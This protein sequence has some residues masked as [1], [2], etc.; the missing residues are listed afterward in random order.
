MTQDIKFS[1]ADY[2]EESM[3]YYTTAMMERNFHH[4]SFKGFIAAEY[5]NIKDG[6]YR[7]IMD[8]KG[9]KPFAI[10][11][12]DSPDVTM[13]NNVIS[14]IPIKG[15]YIGVTIIKQDDVYTIGVNTFN[16]EATKISVRVVDIKTTTEEMLP[17]LELDFLEDII[18]GNYMTAFRA[19]VDGINKLGNEPTPNHLY[20]IDKYAYN[21]MRRI[22]TRLFVNMNGSL[23]TAESTEG[24]FEISNNT[25]DK[26]NG[27]EV[28]DTGI[29]RVYYYPRHSS[30]YK[31]VRGVRLKYLT[32]EDLDK[33][34]NIFESMYDNL[35]VF[36]LKNG[37]EVLGA[38]MGNKYI[39]LYE[40][41]GTPHSLTLTP[42]E[43]R[44][45]VSY[46]TV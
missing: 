3:Q 7:F 6:I 11:T 29:Y 5:L 14:V 20:T 32:R 43:Y 8:E 38:V 44:L 9:K 26:W 12:L 10:R 34:L 46:E 4:G 2:L 30:H 31:F 40:M 42:N 1:E 21:P 45:I 24:I 41:N 37:D 36:T 27:D 39:I 23:C 25:P 19:I 35:R 15:G 22:S 28:Y 16:G 18:D 17:L 13:T 33:N